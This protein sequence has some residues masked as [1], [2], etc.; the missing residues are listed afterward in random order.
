MAT[1]ADIPN[2]FDCI[3]NGVGYAFYDA[4][5][6]KKFGFNDVKALYEYTPT[7][8]AKQNTSGDFGDNQQD[9]WLTFTQRD[10]SL[11]ETQ[12][13]MRV[14]DPVAVRRY[15][16]GSSVEIGKPGQVTLQPTSTTLTTAALPLAIAGADLLT[17]F[18]TSTNLYTIDTAGTIV[19]KGAHGL[20]ASPGCMV[21][22]PSGDLYFAGAA[23]GIRKYDG[24]AFTTFSATTDTYVSLAFNANTLFAASSSALY[25][26]STT[27]VRTALF[28]WQGA[29]GV[30]M[31]LANTKLAAFGGKIAILRGADPTGTELWQYDSTGT[32][33]IAKLPSGFV[34]S[35]LAVLFGV[36]FVGGFVTAYG[37][38]ATFKP[39]IFYYSNGTINKLWEA[40]AASASG[41]SMPMAAWQGGIVFVDTS[42]TLNP[43]MYYNPSTGGTSTLIASTS[44][45]IDPRLGVTKNTVAVANTLSGTSIYF[46]PTTTTSSS[47]TATTSLID[48]E[49]SL[50]KL[51]RGIK[52][53]WEPGSDGNGGS[54]DVAYRVDDVD[55]AYTALQTG[56][57]SGT[58]Y[59][60]TAIS[61][62]SISVKVTLNKGTSTSGP[63]LKRVAVRAA[64]KQPPFRRATYILN[65]TS[66][67][68]KNP[69][70]L[71]DG[72]FD[73]N[74][75]LMQVNNLSSVVT[76]ATP[77]TIIDEIGTY[78]GI[79]EGDS[80]ELRRIRGNEFV[81]FVQCREV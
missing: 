72:T 53:E 49:S 67:D 19:D 80:F 61:G 4:D 56:A 48:Y 33:I 78:T 65:L 1:A 17:Y 73:T 26:L 24:A 54:I 9:F 81:G 66:V 75:G 31:A 50:T 68:G 59:T 16:Q 77:V 47:G 14:N 55:G 43:L 11:G 36:V 21:F 44:A 20:G 79:I 41:L 38:T 64:P 57:V 2:R 34:G 74:D 28:T 39:S 46:Y 12:R 5:G 6:G 3:I 52:V 42:R 45:T 29:D 35:E 69:V 37:A 76:T 71:R 7:F 23:T 40:F 51:F 8:V 60:L 32:A 30:A 15:W 70:K 27:G 25:S 63:K 13:Y 58:E 18:A 62:R 22:D 10:W